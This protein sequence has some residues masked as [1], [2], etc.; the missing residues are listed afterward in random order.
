MNITT[1]AEAYV[2]LSSHAWS[3]TLYTQKDVFVMALASL[4][5]H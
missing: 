1:S 5:G 4:F 3:T 2:S